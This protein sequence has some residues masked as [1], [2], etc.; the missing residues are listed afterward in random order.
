MHTFKDIIEGLE[1][2]IPECREIQIIMLKA[3]NR[4]FNKDEAEMDINEK[5]R[6]SSYIE[7]ILTPY[8]PYKRE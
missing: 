2:T 5:L 7:D 6:L 3:F 8:N 4:K 1:L